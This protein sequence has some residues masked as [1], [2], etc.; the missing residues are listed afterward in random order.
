MAHQ[1]ITPWTTKPSGTTSENEA[2][3]LCVE[4]WAP[5]MA[6]AIVNKFHQADEWPTNRSE[7]FVIINGV[8]YLAVL[9][10]SLQSLDQ[11]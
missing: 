6:N 1:R 11:N 4:V 2:M 7:A 3:A 5:E 9:T 8:E 10:F